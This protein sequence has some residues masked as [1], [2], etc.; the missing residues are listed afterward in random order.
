MSLCFENSYD[1]DEAPV[2][3]IN[4]ARVLEFYWEFLTDASAD[5]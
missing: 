2:V 4:Q 5:Q 1:S 3:K